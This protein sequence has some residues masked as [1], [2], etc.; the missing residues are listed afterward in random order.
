MKRHLSGA[1]KRKVKKQHEDVVNQQKGELDKFMI[2]LGNSGDINKSDAITASTSRQNELPEILEEE[3][4]SEIL[5]DKGRQDM[6][7]ENIDSLP[8]NISLEIY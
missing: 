1:E 5:E 8:E 4:L 6:P 7:V 3:G 2:T